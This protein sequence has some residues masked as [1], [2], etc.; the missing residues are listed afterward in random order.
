MRIRRHC[1]HSVNLVAA[2]AVLLAAGLLARPGRAGDKPDPSRWEKAVAAFEKQDREKPPP[3][4]AIVFVGSSSIRLWDLSKSFP[5]QGAIN[6]GFGG[7]HLSDAVH[8][9]PRL[10]LKHKPRL[11]VL[12]AGDNDIAAGKSPEQVAADFRAFVKAVHQELPQTRVAFLSIKPSVRRWPLWDKMQRA[13][14]LIA[15]YCKQD[16]RL[17]YIDVG[18]PLLGQDGKPRPELF[19]K[20]GLHLNAEGYALWAAAVKPHLK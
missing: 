16:K 15:E 18:K 6:R 19:A 14:A 1:W 7:S 13:N 2:G 8:F 9:A 5:G 4:N 17:L 20:D 3:Q 11:V 12:Y 10:V